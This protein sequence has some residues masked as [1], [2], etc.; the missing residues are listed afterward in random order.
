MPRR[1]TTRRGFLKCS[2]AG[3][4]LLAIGPLARLRAD[5]PPAAATAPTRSSTPASGPR[6]PPNIV[7]IL[8]DDLG[9]G[10]LGCYGA[11]K[12]K[13]PSIDALASRGLRFTDAHSTSAVCTP[14]RYSLMTGQYAWRKPGT[15][16]ASSKTPLL[17][18]PG[19]PTLPQLLKKAGYATACI[20]KWHLG[21]G[22][23]EVDWNGKI[24]PGPLE[25]GFDSCFIIPATGD[26]VPCVFVDGHRVVGLEA[27]DPISVGAEG[28]AAREPTGRD[29]P[30]LL[31][32]KPSRSH[33]GTIINGISRLG[34]MSGGKAARWK[35]EDIADTL[36]KKALDFIEANKAGPFF[37]YFSTHDIHVP[38]IPHQRFAGKSGCGVRGDVVQQL[39]W[40]VGQITDVI[41]RLKLTDNT[42]VIVTSDNGPVVDDG[43][44]D[45][46]RADLNGHEPAA[47]FRDGKYSLY[48]G[49]TRVPFIIRWP[50]KVKAGDS[51]ALV[52][53][54]DLLTSLASV[55]GYEVSG[56]AAPDSFDLLPA[57][58]GQRKDGREYL[59]EQAAAAESLAVR[60]GPWKLIPPAKDTPRAKT[61]LYNLADDPGERN[62]LADQQ[63]AKVKELADLLA[64]VKDNPRS[65][66]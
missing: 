17:M 52:S 36:T 45:G 16:I 50:A 55:A 62:N 49:G 33:D 66:P 19:S 48:E 23:G 8:A 56:D 44:A 6:R 54:L 43:Y 2:V 11:T 21:L 30:E 63:P 14:S 38:R 25:V 41:D 7:F 27:K 15:G 59:I 47:G 9:Y 24:A 12:I 51:A 61:E 5:D 1:I 13:T 37:L 28:G 58:L 65:R 35:D 40:C 3:A 26:R 53:Q 29:N 32:L 31:K 10:D 34:F 39:D 64:R 22:A 4:G 60:K 57:L 18:E 20:G 46:A 42:M